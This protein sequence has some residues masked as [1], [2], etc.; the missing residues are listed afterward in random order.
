MKCEHKIIALLLSTVFI[1]PNL[2]HASPIFSIGEGSSTSWDQAISD[3]NIKAVDDALD[4]G[5]AQQFYSSQI[6]INGITDIVTAT[7]ATIAAAGLVSDGLTT[8]DHDALVMS[9][10]NNNSFLPT[11]L[12]VTAWE[13]VYDVDPDLTGTRVHFSA[14]APTGVWDLSLEL[15]DIFGN[16]RGW[17]AA[18]PA[19]VWTNYWINPATAGIQGPFNAFHEDPGFDL[20]QVVSIRLNESSMGGTAFIDVDPITGFNNPWN[21]W[22]HLSVTAIPLPPAIWMFGTGLVGLLGIA[23]RRKS[24]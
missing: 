2:L 7:N 9:W 10:D 14:Y 15:F 5:A 21:A 11:D 1:A 16:S 6:G 12:V 18:N 13:Y 3:G 20:T 23:K 19:A 8:P 22:N 4:G 24:A 17:F